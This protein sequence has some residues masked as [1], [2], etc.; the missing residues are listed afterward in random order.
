MFLIR[1]GLPKFVETEA[2]MSFR[3]ITRRKFYTKAVMLLI[4]QAFVAFWTAAKSGL[5]A[6][7]P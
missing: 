4:Q 2:G 5:C 6:A 1:K 3:I 7:L